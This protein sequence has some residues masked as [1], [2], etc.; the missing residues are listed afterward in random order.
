MSIEY[1]N[2]KDTSSNKIQTYFM[3]KI[4]KEFL[5]G[6]TPTKEE[7]QTYS[8]TFETSWTKGSLVL[9]KYL[10]EAST[11]HI[12]AEPE[13]KLLYLT[14]N[15]YSLFRSSVISSQMPA[16]SLSNKKTL[17]NLL[18]S[19]SN[20]IP[21][22]LA[23]SLLMLPSRLRRKYSLHIE[24]LFFVNSE[25]E[26]VEIRKIGIMGLMRIDWATFSLPYQLLHKPDLNCSTD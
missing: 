15:T 14:R 23:V 12:E 7:L 5:L 3:R 18:T 4:G 11:Q 24:F 13:S 8:E 17:S 22:T 25:E 9:V 16:Q 20:I 19:F 10:I 1:L 2:L 26:N 6:E 21:R